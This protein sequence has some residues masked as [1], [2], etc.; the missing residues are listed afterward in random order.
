MGKYTYQYKCVPLKTLV[1]KGELLVLSF[2]VIYLMKMLSQTLF[3]VGTFHTIS[4]KES[5]E[6]EN[7]GVLKQAL[8]FSK[9]TYSG[10]NMP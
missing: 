5:M 7:T 8:A 9:I 10:Y 1:E 4:R 6:F 3:P 2:K